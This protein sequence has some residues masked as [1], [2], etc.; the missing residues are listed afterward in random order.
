MQ[1]GSSQPG[2]SCRP[3]APAA[4]RPASRSVFPSRH[5][6]A[7]RVA[8]TVG[9]GASLAGDPTA[10]A[11]G[12]SACPFSA[13][14]Q[15]LSG[16]GA[17]AQRPQQ[18]A[19]AIPGPAPFSLESLQCVSSIFFDGLH[20]AMLKFEKRYGPVCRCVR[21]GD[22]GPARATSD[23]GRGRRHARAS[24]RPSDQ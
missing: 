4:A 13:L 5:A 9:G 19:A 11:T 18:P 3:G 12:A 2:S 24:A 15:Q 21:G 10:S 1:L 7:L 22:G 23:G 16:G 17:A 14:K 8:R 6:S 20:V